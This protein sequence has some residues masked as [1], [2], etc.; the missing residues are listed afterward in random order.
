MYGPDNARKRTVLYK[1]YVL[2]KTKYFFGGDYEIERSQSGIERKLHYISGGDG[3]FAI[4]VMN[5]DGNDSLYYIHKDYL[6][7][8]ET[9]TDSRGSIVSKLSFDPWGRRRDPV[10]WT[11]N[12]SPFPT[13]FDRG[14]TS[15]EHL[16]IFGLINMNGRL[17]DPWLGRM[18]SPDLFIKNDKNTQDYNRYS[19]AMNNPLVFVDP[20]GNFPFI[21]VGIGVLVGAYIGGSAAEGWEMNPGNWNWDK[22][23]WAGIGIGGV[24]GGAAGYGA[25]FL[26]PALASTPLF[27]HFGLSGMAAAYTITGA[28]SGG[29]AGYGAGFAGGM[30]FSNGDWQYSHKSGMM[31]L[32]IGSA[33]GSVVGGIYGLAAGFSHRPEKPQINI[34]YS[35]DNLIAS[36]NYGGF[37]NQQGK[38]T[39][40]DLRSVFFDSYQGFRSDALSYSYISDPI[41]FGETLLSRI[42]LYPNE[43]VNYF[44]ELVGSIA[45]INYMVMFLNSKPDG[46]TSSRLYEFGDDSHSPA[47]ANSTESF[48]YFTYG[49]GLT[50]GQIYNAT[51]IT[52][53]IFDNLY[54]HIKIQWV[55]NWGDVTMY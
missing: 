13:I 17:Y 54:F 49:Y 27:S 51:P 29:I 37:V 43:M 19:Y 14:F 53:K 55:L 11:Y 42:E 31:G 9:V 7:N 28:L 45:K 18:L 40:D 10:T 22:N 4:Y 15:H 39:S 5:D 6:G 30:I 23:T 41:L 20:D 48:P 33:I 36:S 1:D 38:L 46:S 8:I 2:Q 47:L 16:E 26:G 12:K 34:N 24:I 21:I 50:N 35:N 44:P 52:I 32:G 25:S 3:L